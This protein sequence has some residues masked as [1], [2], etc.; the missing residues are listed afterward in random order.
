MLGVGLLTLAMLM[1]VVSRSRDHA[2]PSGVALPKMAGGSTHTETGVRDNALRPSVS[3]A[4]SFT[5]S[6]SKPSPLSVSGTWKLHRGKAI[7][8]LSLSDNR[9][10]ITGT[11][12]QD[13]QW[14]GKS[15][16][17][18]GTRV[19][20]QVEFF[21]SYTDEHP[22][23]DLYQSDVSCRFKGKLQGDQLNGSCVIDIISFF[24]EGKPIPGNSSQLWVA[25]RE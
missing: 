15:H 14:G 6:T 1:L 25:T 13:V 12:T 11:I 21:Y 23:K 10:I 4:P 5:S 9:G 3:Q 19:D 24:R 16:E 18:H 22:S 20:D 7:D 2:L 8:T 17:V